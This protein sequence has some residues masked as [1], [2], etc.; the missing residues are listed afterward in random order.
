MSGTKNANIEIERKYLIKIPDMDILKSQPNYNES[1]IEQMYISSENDGTFKGDRIRKRVYP[2]VTKYYKTHKEYISGLSKIEIE[3][4]ISEEEYRELS[5]RLLPN[6]RV[7]RKVRHCFDF[8]GQVVELDIYEFWSDKATAEVEIESEEQ[9][10]TLPKF[11][12]VIADVTG[13][14]SYS[15]FAL[16]ELKKEE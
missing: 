3:N 13:D 7:I 11:I 14:K 4:E 16:A 12:E 15:N 9:A 10:V 2:D 1:Y 8:E 5:K 6:S